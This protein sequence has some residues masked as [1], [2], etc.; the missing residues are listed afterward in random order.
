MNTMNTYVEKYYMKEKTYNTGK[1]FVEHF[2][3]QVLEGQQSKTLKIHTREGQSSLSPL[4]LVNLM[5]TLTF[6]FILWLYL[7]SKIIEDRV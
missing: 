1:P 3:S 6:T 4:V 2:P 7:S 5:L